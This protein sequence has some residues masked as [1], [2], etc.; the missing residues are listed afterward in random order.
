MRELLLRLLVLTLLAGWT[1]GAHAG[2]AAHQAAAQADYD[3]GG[4]RAVI[5][6]LMQRNRL[7]SVAVAVA[8]RGTI[9][10]D[11]GFGWAD[12]ERRARATPN[13]MYSLAS[14]SKPITATALMTLAER[15]A[16]DLN[17]P[18]GDYLG[19][20]RITG[21]AG[22]PAAA[23]V[24]RVMSHTAG[25]PLHYQFFY[26]TDTDRPPAM[27]STIARYGILIHRPG[28][29]YE[30]SNLGY[31]ILDRV[32]ARA[33]ARN[34]PDYVRE[35]VFVPL[36]MTHTSVHVPRELE[37]FAAAR[38]DSRNAPIPFYDFDHV[39]AS[40]VWASARDL[41]RF[42]MFHLRDHSPGQRRIL[43][44]STILAMQRAATPAAASGTYGLGWFT[45]ESDHGFRR[46]FHTGSMPGVA[47]ILNIYPTEDLA[48]VVLLNKLDRAARD[49]IAQEIA[50]ALL[51]RYAASLRAERARATRATTPPPVAAPP[52]LLGE[53]SGTLR[54]YQGTVP[55]S[56]TI[57]SEGTVTLMLAGQDST[58]L[59][60]VSYRDGNLMG[61][62]SG[63]IPT[64][65]A[66]RYPHT[67]LLSLRLREGRLLGRATAQTPGE[68]VHFALSSYVDL[69]RRGAAQ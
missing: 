3:F 36:G 35:E 16:V 28:A 62:A 67:V 45:D 41:V 10:W 14:I 31:G 32:I 42:A 58:P 6:R 25:L 47:T 9:V 40:A 46:V 1:A 48:V 55:M 64:D 43:A 13:T 17:R 20:A 52:E 61:R 29:V 21:L 57:R 2:A 26:E 53:W 37:A 5:R 54:T 11:E 15:G 50:A 7:P 39:G 30:Y 49:R 33:S 4:A 56:L 51:P 68:P 69:A 22:D 44:D 18:V 24:R 63:V 66:R 65:D 38:Y 12:V 34:Y 59:D 60:G 23:T 19:A 8:Y 27:D